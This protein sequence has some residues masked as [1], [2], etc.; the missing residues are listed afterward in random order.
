MRGA[1]L[2]L[3]RTPDSLVESSTG[4]SEGSSE[5]VGRRTRLRIAVGRRFHSVR[6]TAPRAPDDGS[7]QDSSDSPHI[8][9]DGGPVSF[10]GMSVRLAVPKVGI[11]D[12]VCPAK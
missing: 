11:S 12:T 10:V 2:A 3:E 7:V 1:S 4:T 9:I 8:H 6:R 5:T